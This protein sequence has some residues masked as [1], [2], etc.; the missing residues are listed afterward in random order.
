MIGRT[1]LVGVPAIL[2]VDRTIFR[3]FVQLPGEAL[4]IS[5][6]H[7]RSAMESHSSLRQVMMNYVQAQMTWQAQIILCN[8]RHSLRQRVAR[9]LLMVL[10]CIDGNDVPA[11]H[12]LLARMLGVRRASISETIHELET[13]GVLSA[14]RG[15]LKVLD[16]TSLAEAACECYSLL[17]SEFNR[18]VPP[19]EARAGTFA[20]DKLDAFSEAFRLKKD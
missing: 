7:L 1:G 12:D 15:Q 17:R 6:S 3:C 8:T 2:G 5:I 16:R 19:G 14:G 11:T 20:Q 10:D 4:R 9:W 13:C 18:L